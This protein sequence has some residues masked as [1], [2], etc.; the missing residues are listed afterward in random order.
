MIR[1]YVDRPFW[2][3]TLGLAG[4]SGICAFMLML[5]ALRDGGFADWY[6]LWNLFLAWI[7]LLLAYALVRILRR[8]PWSS[9]PGI[10]LSLG[11]LLFLPN[12]FY[13]VSDLIH[14]EDM[15][16]SNVLFDA[17]T[18][19]VFVLN[20]LILGY[21]SLYLVQ[22]ALS[23]R[24]KRWQSELFVPAMLLLSSFAIYLGRDLRW[25]SWDVLTSPAGIIF[26]VS[27]R[28]ID[29]LDH[30]D[31][32]TTTLMFFLFLAGLYLTLGVMVRAVGDYAR[33]HDHWR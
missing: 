31:A 14:L 16:R 19:T 22:Q 8:K 20:G 11:W 32:F 10:G 33:T 4:L 12:S 24:V 13:M 2:K 7:P 9:W 27:E 30:P 1:K 17:L 26:D 23:S 28:V 15:P 29:P 5:G 6:L 18:F 21:A 25:N 3:F